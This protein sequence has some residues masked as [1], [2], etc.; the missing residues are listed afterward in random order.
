MQSIKDIAKQLWNNQTGKI[1]LPID[2]IPFVVSVDKPTKTAVYIV[3][4]SLSAAMIISA[5]IKND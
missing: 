4:G 2:P 3:A 1:Q 5:L